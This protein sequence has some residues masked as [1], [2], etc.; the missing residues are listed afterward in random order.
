MLT[1]NSYLLH[2]GA[3]AFTCGVSARLSAIRRIIIPAAAGG[4]FVS[5]LG[6]DEYFTHTGTFKYSAAKPRSLIFLAPGFRGVSKGI[7]TA[8]ELVAVD[9]GK[10]ERAFG[11]LLPAMVAHAPLQAGARDSGSLL[12]KSVVWNIAFQLFASN[13]GQRP[14]RHAAPPGVRPDDVLCRRNGRRAR[15][16]IPSAGCK[17][18][19]LACSG[20][21]GGV[22]PLRSAAPCSSPAIA[23]ALTVAAQAARARLRLSAC[24]P[25]LTYEVYL[26]HFP[27]IQV[28]VATGFLPPPVSSSS[29]TAAAVVILPAPCAAQGRAQVCRR[30]IGSAFPRQRH[31]A[32]PPGNLYR[33]RGVNSSFIVRL[34]NRVSYPVSGGGRKICLRYFKIVSD[35]IQNMSDIFLTC[36][37]GGIKNWNNNIH[38]PA[39]ETDISPPLDVHPSTPRAN[40][41]QA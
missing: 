4:A 26:L 15:A 20:A 24:T 35:I 3:G 39:P 38:I 30:K 21:A 1:Y 31:K 11:I 2:P 16:H 33:E 9:D 22:R 29:H 41:L 18:A 14:L 5:T 10:R 17:W 37:Q 36:S 25:N 32:I 40:A 13:D 28:L 23:A 6:A 7:V 19:V 8:A 34:F 27:V 12:V